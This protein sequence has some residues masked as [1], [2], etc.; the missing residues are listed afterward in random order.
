MRLGAGGSHALARRARGLV[1]RPWDPGPYGVTGVCK[2]APGLAVHGL[3]HVR[4]YP[5]LQ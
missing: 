3:G 4:L 5:E 1:G 2:G